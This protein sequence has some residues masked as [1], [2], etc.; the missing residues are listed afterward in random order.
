MAG[1]NLQIFLQKLLTFW[2]PYTIMYL[3]STKSEVS[4]CPHAQADQKWL[5]LKGMV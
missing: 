3:W 1:F 2:P 5:I 4:K